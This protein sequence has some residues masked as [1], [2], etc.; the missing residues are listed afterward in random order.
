MTKR[1]AVYN[2]LKVGLRTLSTTLCWPVAMTC[3]AI[4]LSGLCSERGFLYPKFDDVIQV[5]LCSQCLGKISFI[6]N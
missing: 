2:N 3:E 1:R 4:K 5:L 6:V